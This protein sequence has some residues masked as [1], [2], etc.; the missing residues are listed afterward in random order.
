[1]L[2]NMKYAMLSKCVDKRIIGHRFLRTTATNP[3]SL[4]EIPSRIEGN[5]PLAKCRNFAWN[6]SARKKQ[7][8]STSSSPNNTNEN[9]GLYSIEG[10]NKPCDFL[11]LASMSI[12]SCN[13]IRQSLGNKL[14]SNTILSNKQ[15]A[16]II[17]KELDDISNLVCC[18]ID[19]AELCRNTHSNQEWRD[20]AE[21]VFGMLSSYIAELNADDTLY[22]I[23]VEVNKSS[24]IDEL[25]EEERRFGRVLQNEFERD[26]I[27]LSIE[28]R[29]EVATIQGYITG[30][31]ITINFCCFHIFNKH[32]P[33]DSLQIA[34][35]Y[36]H[37]T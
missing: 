24:V 20:Y 11:K 1:M 7:Y 8:K 2:S 19:A 14:S 25:N 21:K 4:F 12:D 35:L 16:S 36:F 18:V 13:K 6:L 37:K 17:L 30:K 9:V 32:N 27:H 33:N 10:L 26:G 23:L 29:N 22:K 5:G 28:Q 31:L 3:L 34:K 15:D